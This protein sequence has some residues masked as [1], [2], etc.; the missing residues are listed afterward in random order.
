MFNHILCP[1][2]GS[3]A[4]HQALDIAAK[5]AQEQHA[6]LTIC[7][8]VDPSQAAAMA[9]GDPGMS[10]ACYSALEDESKT[11]VAEAAARLRGCVTAFAVTLIGQPVA[12]IVSQAASCGADLIVMGSHGRSGIPR[13]FLGSV[14]EE[15]L[16]RATI[17]VM[18]I[19]YT[20][21]VKG[22]AA[23]TAA[24]EPATA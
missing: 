24:P 15:V 6:A 12:G 16:R 17:P 21:H 23:E 22:G 1:I 13:A 3:Q 5:L 7:S 11:L 8:V 10:A 9:F 2:D 14:A 19:R 18:I 4:A 20:Q